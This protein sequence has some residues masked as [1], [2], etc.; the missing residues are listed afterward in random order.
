[1]AL[2]EWAQPALAYWPIRVVVALVV[3]S[4]LRMRLALVWRVVKVLQFPVLSLPL[5]G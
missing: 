5:A 4:L 1:V 2:A 3:V